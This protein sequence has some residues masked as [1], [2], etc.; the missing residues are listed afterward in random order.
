MSTMEYTTKGTIELRLRK[1]QHINDLIESITEFQD[2]SKCNSIWY[3]GLSCSKYE[4]IPSL[5]RSTYINELA[6]IYTKEFISR[7]K[8]LINTPN[9]YSVW[10]WYQTMQHCGAPTRLLDWTE[11]YLI[12]LYFALQE[13]QFVK[14]REEIKDFNPC[15]WVI[16]PTSLNNISIQ[17]EKI[18]YTDKL[19][20]N[21]NE[22]DIDTFINDSLIDDNRL[23]IAIYPSH[24]N[25]RLRVQ[26]GCFT[27]HFS[28]ESLEDIIRNKG[29]HL[30][31]F[32][33]NPDSSE[34]ILDELKNGGITESTLFPDIDGLAKE[35]KGWLYY[36][37]RK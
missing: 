30:C 6:N 32:L 33:I 5:F 17:S 23:P 21:E 12:A 20:R 31:Q 8:G 24:T 28:E 34:E 9:D 15:I 18:L 13:L 7:G 29:I 26:K 27:L 3:R 22:K 1:I 10:D 11:G 25:V 36:K 14:K 4:L 2:K 19:L 37:H 35:L 16:S